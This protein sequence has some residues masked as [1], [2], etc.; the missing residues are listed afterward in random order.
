MLSNLMLS[1]VYA[2][3]HICSVLLCWLLFMLS[4]FM[5]FHAKCCLCLVSYF[6]HCCYAGGYL[7][8]GVS[9]SFMLNV[10]SADCHILFSAVML[11][12]INAEQFYAEYSLCWVSY[13]LSAVKL[14]VIYAE[15]CLCWVSYFGQ[16]CYAGCYLC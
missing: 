15:Y 11:V 10:V 6:A 5:Q 4:S 2:E 1:T 8:W 14:V 3:C 16:C 13:L 9:C 7:C 12:V